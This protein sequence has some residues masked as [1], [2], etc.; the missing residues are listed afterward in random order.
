MPFPQQGVAKNGQPLHYAVGAVIEREGKFLLIDRAI[1]P[2]GFAGIAGHV[3]EKELPEEA[4][5][6]EVQEEAGV[7]VEKYKLLLEKEIDGVTCSRGI[8]VHYWYI[9]SCTIS[10]TITTNTREVKS[11]G[12]FTPNE[13]KKLPLEPSFAYLLKA[14]RII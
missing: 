5:C 4:L 9:Y 10:G 11:F 3:D 8:G 12:W 1:T 6:R 7:T 13:I 14:I 2:Y